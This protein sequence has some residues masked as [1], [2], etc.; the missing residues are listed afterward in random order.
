MSTVNRVT[1]DFRGA[2]AS[3]FPYA[4]FTRDVESWSALAL[5]S[6][7]LCGSRSQHLKVVSIG[8]HVK[9]SNGAVPHK[10]VEEGLR[11]D[12]SLCDPQPHLAG[13]RKVSLVETCGLHDGQE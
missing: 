7:R 4:H 1:L 5:A 9:A 11:D 3:C 6:N 2:M 10:V 12:G 13:R 8:R